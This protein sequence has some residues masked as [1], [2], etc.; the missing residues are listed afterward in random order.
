MLTKG[1]YLTIEQ[2]HCFFLPPDEV[3]A[4]ME[5]AVAA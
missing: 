4:V 2:H 1:A 3:E 5:A